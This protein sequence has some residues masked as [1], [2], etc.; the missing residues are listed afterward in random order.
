MGILEKP[1]G[2]YYYINAVVPPGYL[3]RIALGNNDTAGVARSKIAKRKSQE[4]AA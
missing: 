2:F 1:C 3:G 4:A